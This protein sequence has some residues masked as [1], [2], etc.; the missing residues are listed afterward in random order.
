MLLFTSR[1][2]VALR[3]EAGGGTCCVTSHRNGSIEVPM[4]IQNHNMCVL[5]LCVL[6]VYVCVTCVATPVH[7]PLAVV[8]VCV[9]VCAVLRVA[10]FPQRGAEQSLS[11]F[12]PLAVFFLLHTNRTGSADQ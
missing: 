2:L 6:P 8:C 10:V 3:Q 12:G 4:K 5:P 9:S 11:G 1:Q 7:C